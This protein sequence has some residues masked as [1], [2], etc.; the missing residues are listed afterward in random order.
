MN[1]LRSWSS[2]LAAAWIGSV[3]GLAAAQGL[4]ADAGVRSPWSFSVSGFSHDSEHQEWRTGRWLPPHWRTG[5][6][7]RLGD[8][9]RPEPVSLLSGMTALRHDRT[10]GMSSVAGLDGT[11]HYA[12]PFGGLQVFGGGGAGYYRANVHLGLPDADRVSDLGLH[13]VAGVSMPL[14][15]DA[16]VGVSLRRVWIQRDGASLVRG[17]GEQGGNYLFLGLR[18]SR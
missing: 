18:L 14:A 9:S 6:A 4:R 12:L 8:F 1:Q 3:P 7:P 5:V 16:E 2:I 13:A 17:A 15:D 10:V 11:A